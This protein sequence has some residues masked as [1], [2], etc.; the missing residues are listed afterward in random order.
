MNKPARIAAAGANTAD[1][2]DNAGN[3]DG[4]DYSGGADNAPTPT[5]RRGSSLLELCKN[6][7]WADMIDEL[8]RSS[9][10]SGTRAARLLLAVVG[11]GKGQ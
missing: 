10:V 4:A 7:Q 1:D 6:E 11:S 5:L 8:A 2:A 9:Q 3:E